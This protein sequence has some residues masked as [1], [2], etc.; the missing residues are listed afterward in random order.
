MAGTKRAGISIGAMAFLSSALVLLALM[1]AAG[2][3]TR[4]LPA[5]TFDRIGEG[6]TARVDPESYRELPRPD[7]PAWR[8]FTAPVEVLGSEDGSAAIA[9]ILFIMI[10]GGSFAVMQE[11]GI[12]AAAVRA[13]ATRF[14]S[15]KRLLLALVALFFMLIGSLMGIFE[16]V[17]P[18]V[19]LAIALS[20]SLGWDVLTGLGMSVLATCFG[21]SAAISN[22]F[23]IGVA[24]RVAGLPLFSGA[25]FRMLCFAAVYALLLAWLLATARK[26]EKGR[27]L[28]GA[29]GERFADELSTPGVG[30]AD[31]ADGA[32]GAAARS[33][34]PLKIKR[35]VIFFAAASALLA[36]VMAVSLEGSLSDYS[37]PISALLFLAAGLG[38]GLVAGL[39]AREAA[40]AFGQGA[41]GLLPGV[42][43]ILMALSVKRIIVQG[44]ILDTI[45]EASRRALVDGPF[46]AAGAYG[47]AGLVYLVTLGIE[48]FVGSATAKAFLLMPIIAP[49][50][51][52]AD[53]SRQTAVQ[54]FAFGD[55]FSNMLYPT[56]PVLLICLGIAGLSWP[57]W[58][59][60]TWI[61]QAGVLV[62]TAAL[63]ALAIATRYS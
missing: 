20:V 1:I 42:V 62:L 50:A 5:G 9:I 13:M 40:R 8:W 45:L 17:V 35:G 23:S 10:V 33:A 25:L 36:V 39:R 7:Y 59:R 57:A 43:L 38:S 16:E 56:N 19:P 29:A 4:L 11:A 61:L 49:L 63:L 2:A 32:D 31:G 41:L 58:F 12:L 44:M 18:L 47:A 46:A 28:S 26:A 60:R 6:A 27:G 51:D 14:G 3:L 24:Q 54:A 48:F 21:F 53:L 15:R 34:D 37:M 30:A 52:I 55:G 22:P